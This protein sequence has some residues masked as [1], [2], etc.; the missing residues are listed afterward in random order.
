MNIHELTRIASN[1]NSIPNLIESVAINTNNIMKLQQRSD[2]H[3]IRLD[4][5]EQVI[6]NQ[7][8]AIREFKQEVNSR[9]DKFEDQVNSRLDKFKQEVKDCL[10]K[11]DQRMDNMEKK[12]DD[13]ISLLKNKD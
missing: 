2:I 10:D 12:L 1:I 5:A 4:N 3:N 8:L 9:L 11:S 7:Y 13:I 6:D